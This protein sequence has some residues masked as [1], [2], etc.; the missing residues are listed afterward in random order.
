MLTDS[1]VAVSSVA[2]FREYFRFARHAATMIAMMAINPI[3]AITNHI[4]QGVATTM[5]VTPPGSCADFVV[6]TAVVSLEVDVDVVA[7]VD[8]VDV[9]SD[10]LRSEVTGPVRLITTVVL[11]KSLVAV[12][13][14]EVAAA[15]TV[16]F[17]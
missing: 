16:L 12:G 17:P 9:S 13:T 15:S 7:V 1:L 10:V 5:T 2:S 4:H 8:V 6:V 14:L 11:L 3:N